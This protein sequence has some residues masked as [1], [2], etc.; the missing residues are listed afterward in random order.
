M[1]H[2]TLILQQMEQGDYSSTEELL[3]LVYD[4]LRQMAAAQML[5]ERS[6]HTL[7]PTALVHEAFLRLVNGDEVRHWESRRHFFGAAAEAMRRILV[8]HARWQLA[9][10]HGGNHRRVLADDLAGATPTDPAVIL[11]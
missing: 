9:E 7:Q 11:D 5:G 4:E 10:K 8:D 1:K 2:V 3:P 6:D